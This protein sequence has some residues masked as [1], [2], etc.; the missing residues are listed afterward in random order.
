L[1][2]D[3]KWFGIVRL[4]HKN[5]KAVSLSWLLSRRRGDECG[6]LYFIPIGTR[7]F[8]VGVMIHIWVFVNTKEFPHLSIYVRSFVKG[9]VW[10]AKAMFINDQSWGLNL[11]VRCDLSD[12]F[13]QN[14]FVFK[15]ICWVKVVHQFWMMKFSQQI[16]SV[17]KKYQND[18][19]SWFEGDIDT[20]WPT[21]LRNTKKNWEGG[22]NMSG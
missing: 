20:K 14:K 19:H 1:E 2:L 12:F 22:F 18:D 3:Q 6:Q 10:F 17:E 7:V 16:N 13:I 4:N 9:N 5:F 11:D 21:F 8:A 15:K